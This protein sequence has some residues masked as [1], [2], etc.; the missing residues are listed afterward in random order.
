MPALHVFSPAPLYS[1][2]EGG[3]SSSQFVSNPWGGAR[4]VWLQCTTNY[5]SGG[6]ETEFGIYEVFDLD[7]R[8]NFRRTPYGTD[9]YGTYPA[10]LFVGRLLGV[11]VVART[12]DAIIE[13]TLTLFLWG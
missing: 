9:T 8:G 13:G 5:V 6:G 12:Y 11:T 1:W 3:N 2:G 7:E 10:R 4:P